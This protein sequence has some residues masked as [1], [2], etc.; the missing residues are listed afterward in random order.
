MWM[1]LGWAGF[2]CHLTLAAEG[3]DEVSGRWNG[4]TKL[5]CG[6][7]YVTFALGWCSGRPEKRRSLAFVCIWFGGGIGMGGHSLRAASRLR[8][9]DL[10]SL[11]DFLRFECVIIL[12]T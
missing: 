8:A 1:W 5:A 3:G 10:P 12:S 6:S 2:A 9:W 7:A 4:I 11:G